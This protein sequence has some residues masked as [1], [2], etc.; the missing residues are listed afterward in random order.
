MSTVTLASQRCVRCGNE[1]P[2]DSYACSFC[3]KRLRIEK[4]ENIRFFSRYGEN[5]EWTNPYP[6]YTKIFY[7]FIRPNVAFWDINHKRSKAPGF[8]ILLFNS[9]LYGLMGLACFSHFYMVSL[10]PFSPMLFW[11]NLSMFIA[12]FAFGFV[13]QFLF[14]AIQIWLFIKGANLAVD[15]SKRLERRFGEEKE[16]EQKFKREELSPFSIYRGG[17]LL[18][19]QVAYKFRMMLCA[20]APFLLIN[21]IKTLIILIAFPTININVS[22]G[23]YE[24]IFIVM[25]E[26]PVWAVLDVIDAVTLAAWVP[27]LMTLSM[28]ELSNASTLRILIPSFVI[29]ILIAIF[30]YFL[31]PTL[32]G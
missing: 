4:I 8:L 10:S 6:W 18:Q 25:F 20:F 9:L 15:F 12:F 2:A 5:M 26:S 14:F 24:N 23:F 21:A 31:R 19:K 22:G 1:N 28:R 7:L 27:I 32:F 16:E 17:T 30:F 13:F 29:G 11:Y 3:G